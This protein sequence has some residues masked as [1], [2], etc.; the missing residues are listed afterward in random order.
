M[1]SRYQTR[2]VPYLTPLH[3]RRSYGHGQVFHAACPR[4]KDQVRLQK[5]VVSRILPIEVLCDRFRLLIIPL[6]YL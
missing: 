4:G 5:A 2:S 3:W 6:P 1:R